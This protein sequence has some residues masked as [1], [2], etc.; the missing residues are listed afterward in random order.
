MLGTRDMGREGD[1]ILAAPADCHLFRSVVPAGALCCRLIDPLL[2][3]AQA[4]C[5]PLPTIALRRFL[6]G[7][8]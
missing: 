8:R 1:S 2:D 3:A 6:V 7:P 5:E 4:V